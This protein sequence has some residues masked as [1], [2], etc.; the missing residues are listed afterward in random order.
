MESAHGD[1]MSAVKVVENE[2]QNVF[3]APFKELVAGMSQVI[4]VHGPA[5][6]AMAGLQSAS[7]IHEGITK[8]AGDDGIMIDKKYV[9]RQI[10]EVGDSISSV[11]QG[12]KLDK[13]EGTVNLLDPGAEKLAASR[14]QLAKAMGEFSDLLRSKSLAEVKSTFKA[15]IG[16]WTKTCLPEFGEARWVQSRSPKLKLVETGATLRR[17][18][19]VYRYN[20]CLAML[21]RCRQEIEAQRVTRLNL[22]RIQLSDEAV[23][24]PAIA[25]FMQT[26]YRDVKLM[27][28]RWLYN[29][30]RAYN[31]EAL[32]SKDIVGPA[33]R[34][35]D[36]TG[37]DLVRTNAITLRSAQGKLMDAFYNEPMIA[38]GERQ[39]FNQLQY[40]LEEDRVKAFKATDKS[41]IRSYELQLGP[42][43]LAEEGDSATVGESP[44]APV[45]AAMVDVRL[46]KVRLFLEDAYTTS[47]VLRVTL[48]HVGDEVIYDKYQKAI[49]FHHEPLNVGFHYRIQNNDCKG[50]GTSDGDIGREDRTGNDRFS[51]VG[52]FTSWWVDVRPENNPGLDLS[53]VKK[54]TLEFE[55]V[56]RAV[57]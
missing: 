28:Q 11:Y 19:A 2:I 42:S 54:A 55:G 46:T 23:N 25:H 37:N 9:I 27:A 47:G 35:S 5:T 26:L 43:E 20:T 31:F 36:S 41:G 6:V 8:V 15:Y 45:F 32:N 38:A 14:D 52:P 17:N 18:S 49:Q 10:E 3:T 12:Y 44:L 34:G 1:L 7:L 22:G 16:K 39:P 13:K 24:Y 40:K 21:A 48:T 57:R 29:A 30:Q 56:Y 33:L 50:R 4:M 53:E 51:L